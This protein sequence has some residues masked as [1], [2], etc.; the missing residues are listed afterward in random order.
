MTL[1]K[2][3][4]KSDDQVRRQQ[5]TKSHVTC[6][7]E[8]YDE[9]RTSAAP[10]F[11]IDQDTAI[12]WPKPAQTHE[13]LHALLRDIQSVLQ[14]ITE[15]E[16]HMGV[17]QSDRSI[18][19]EHIQLG[20]EVVVGDGHVRACGLPFLLMILAV[21]TTMVLNAYKYVFST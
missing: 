13:D 8:S 2:K 19:H 12:Q 16:K 6:A 17:S 3:E 4:K 18:R 1:T 7:K 10:Q 21:I 14:R 11:R 5:E 20:L 15:M 9:V